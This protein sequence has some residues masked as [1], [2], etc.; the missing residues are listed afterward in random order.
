MGA[1]RRRGHVRHQRLPA[2]HLL[3]RVRC[4]GDW[5]GP[6]S[7]R[8][9]HAGRPACRWHEFR[10]RA[11]V[12]STVGSAAL[13]NFLYSA[14]F[15]VGPIQAQR[16]YHGVKGRALVLTCAGLGSLVGGGLALRV[17]PA[18]PLQASCLLITALGL[19]A[20]VLG[21]G[22]PLPAVA[23]AA[24]AGWAGL[25]GSNALWQTALQQHV[26]L[27]VLSRVSA[28]GSAGSFA[29]IPLGLALAGPAAG[30]RPVP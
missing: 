21:V 11:W 4:G 5:T 10:S 23:V 22:L 24:A 2:G 27:E 8:P 12:W 6:G 19:P 9:V 18:H 7:A 26:P 25:T 16:H 20:L 30:A 14:F 13:Q 17:R 15:V 3:A 28:Y 29:A 1:R